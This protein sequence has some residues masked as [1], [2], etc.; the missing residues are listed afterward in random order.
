MDYSAKY[1]TFFQD[2]ICENAYRFIFAVNPLK[3]M[4]RRH[5]R[6]V[7]PKLY[8][9]EKQEAEKWAAHENHFFEYTAWDN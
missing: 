3:Y 7:D 8:E 6:I 4:N 2:I 5:K 1:T 9:Q